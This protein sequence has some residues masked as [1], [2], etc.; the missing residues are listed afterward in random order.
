MKSAYDFKLTD[1]AG[2]PVDMQQYHGK[3]LLIVNTASKC[4]LWPQ[5]KDLQKVHDKYKKEGFEVLAFPSD[6]FFQEPKKGK[7]I[8]EACEVNFGVTFKIMAKSP[9]RGADAQPFYK[10]LAKEAGMSPLWNFH[11]YI[12][13][14]NGKVVDWFNPWKRAV[15]A[16]VTGVIEKCLKQKAVEMSAA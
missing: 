4:G 15:D 7:E 11:K 5:M 10:F 16:K 9:V 6:S 13:D 3:V 2:K 14:R 8:A 12:I 1:L